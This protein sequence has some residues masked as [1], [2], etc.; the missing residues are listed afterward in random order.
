MADV[1]E[2]VPLNGERILQIV[3][4]KFFEYMKVTRVYCVELL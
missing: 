4:E 3:A 1:V 2:S